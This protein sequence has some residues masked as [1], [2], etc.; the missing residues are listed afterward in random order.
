MI[1]TKFNKY[2]FTYFIIK[3]FYMFFAIFVYSKLT[4]LGDTNMYL[5]G[6]ADLSS[7]FFSSTEMMKFLGGTFSSFLGSTM[8][9]LPFVILSFYGIYYS[10][11][12]ITLTNKQLFIVLMLLSFPSFGVWTSICSKEAFGVFYMG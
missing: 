2:W 9:N 5:R 10:V 6:G 8:A 1:K 11:S 12:K 7:I 3:L 4:T